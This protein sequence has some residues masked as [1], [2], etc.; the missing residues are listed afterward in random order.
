VRVVSATI[1]LRG[2]A[3]RSLFTE[4]ALLVN[5]GTVV[6]YG[7]EVPNQARFPE[8]TVRLSGY[9]TAMKISLASG[10]YQLAFVVNP[11]YSILLPNFGGGSFDVG[12]APVDLGVVR[13][14]ATWQ[15]EGD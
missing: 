4:C 6:I 12:E 9:T 5:G 3:C 14:S 11:P 10:R 15:S 2:A 1:D 13:P 8:H 7:P